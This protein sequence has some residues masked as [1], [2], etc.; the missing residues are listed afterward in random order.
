MINNG[1]V[2]VF[3]FSRMII[4]KL[5]NSEFCF[6]TQTLSVVQGKS[7]I[8]HIGYIFNDPSKG[9]IVH[10]TKEHGVIR[11]AFLPLE[12]VAEFQL[13][14]HHSVFDDNVLPDDDSDDEN[15]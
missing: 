12:S 2:P 13:Q 3:Q 15:V 5:P 7:F 1:H 10:C 4:Q 6:S 9:I 14:H 8:T 11:E